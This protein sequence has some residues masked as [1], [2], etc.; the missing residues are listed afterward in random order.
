MINPLDKVNL[1]VYYGSIIDKQDFENI[2]EKL[3]MQHFYNQISK[4]G[5]KFKDVGQ[6]GTTWQYVVGKE[7]FW[8]FTDHIFSF[9]FED[10]NLIIDE[11]DVGELDKIDVKEK[12]LEL[13]ISAE[14][15]FYVFN[16]WKEKDKE[17][18]EIEIK[19]TDSK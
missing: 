4:H 14:P 9:K 5:L 1:L 11:Q 7:L 13:N 3:G 15:K 17:D 8:D 18:I 10:G 12:L 16:S 19:K 6:I 2:S